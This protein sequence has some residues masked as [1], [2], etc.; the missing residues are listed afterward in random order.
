MGH[1]YFEEKGVVPLYMFI[2]GSICIQFV[3]GQLKN[4]N[5]SVYIYYHLLRPYYKHVQILKNVCTKVPTDRNDFT[6]VLILEIN[7]N[8]VNCSM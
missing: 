5:S 3:Q 2:Y 1:L 6:I 4:A 7:Q 8:N